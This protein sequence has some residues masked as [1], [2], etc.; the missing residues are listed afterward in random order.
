MSLVIL[1]GVAGALVAVA[2]AA[3]LWRGS[4]RHEPPVRNAYRWFAVAALLWGAGFVAQEA[5]AASGGGTSLTFADLL[6]LLALPAIGIG[7]AGQSRAAG[8]DRAAPRA[9]ARGAL[10]WLADACLMAAALFVIAWLAV[11]GSE[12]HKLG[13]S[14]GVFT[15]QAVHPIADILALG[16]LL[17]LAVRAGRAGLTPYLALFVVAVGESLAVGARI[18][19]MRPGPW[20][21]VIQLAGFCLLGVSAL[22]REPGEAPSRWRPGWPRPDVLPEAT[23]LAALVAG[24]AALMTIGWALAGE[25]FAEPAVLASGGV[26]GLALVARIT[27]L[28]RDRKSVV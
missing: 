15:T 26:A 20:S 25:S 18:S 5:T 8:G 7:L 2:A 1:P 14:P 24:V 16:V 12:Y 23:L 22:A 6:S 17:A 19:G 10:A 3:G 27:E 4:F 13:E 9:Q 28:L 11:F 21:V